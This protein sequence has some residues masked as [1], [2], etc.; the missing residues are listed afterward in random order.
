MVWMTLAQH[1]LS[2]PRPPR[3]AS[4]AT[5]A[6]LAERFTNLSAVKLGRSLAIRHVAIGSCNGCELE[7]RATQNMIHDLTQYGLS[8]T[9]SPRHADILLITGVAARNMAEALRQ[10]RAAT[11]DPVFTIAVGD[12]AVDGGVFKGSPAITGGADSILP[13]DLMISGCPP[14]PSQIIEGLL[15][16]IEAHAG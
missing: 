9:P 7:L 4:Q 6:A 5:A 15:S 16:L 8:F 2:K 14:T 11:P 13:I 12:C 3:R 1:L 10:A